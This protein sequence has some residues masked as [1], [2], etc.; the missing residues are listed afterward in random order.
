MNAEK[1]HRIK[2]WFFRII[3]IILIIPLVQQ[4]FPL[5]E[6]KPLGGYVH[7]IE[8]P[9]FSK[10]DWLDEKYQIDFEKYENQNFGFRNIFV[11]INNQIDYSVNNIAHANEVV[12]GR[13]GYLYEDKYIKE[14]FG[15]NYVGDQKI[16][17]MTAK[18]KKVQDT[19]KKLNKDM[20]VVLAPGKA[21]YHPEFIPEKLIVEKGMTNYAAYVQEFTNNGI[22]YVDFNKWFLEMKPKV[23][24]P[25]YG[26]CGIHWSKYAELLAADSLVNYFHKNGYESISR[27][28]VDEIIVNKK[29]VEGDYDI[30]DGMNLLF[31]MDVYPMAYPR[32]HM[33]ENPKAHNPKVLVVADSYYWGMYNSGIS[34]NIFNNGKF[35]F[36]NEQI[37]PDSYESP[38]KVAD[39]HIQ[40][41]VEKNDAVILLT[42]DANLYKLGFGFIDQLYEKYYSTSARNR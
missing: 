6:I 7:I 21:T 9:V 10:A 20:I 16:V 12:V 5:V 39:I 11:R 4:L 37:F 35:W 24:Y 15:L 25:V 30:G 36:Y 34:S 27:I 40:E 38:K 1:S 13:D 19:L 18:L 26:K 3:L 23:K 32:F 31:E 2:V 29:N 41:E 28:V 42:T 33:T 17:E 8:K 14:Y 22:N